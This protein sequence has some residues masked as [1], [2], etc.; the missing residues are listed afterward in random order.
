MMSK[1]APRRSTSWSSRARAAARSLQRLHHVAE[2]ADL[3]AEGAGRRVTHIGGEEPDGVVAP[4]VPEPALEQVAVVHEVMDRHE[5]DRGDAETA[6]VVDDRGMSDAGVGAAEMLGHVGM[7][8]SQALD[9]RLVDHGLVPRDARRPIVT[10]RERGVDDD[11]LRHAVRAVALVAREI[12]VGV[13]DRVPEQR[14]AP[15]HGARERAR[16]RVDQK[17]R[18]VEAVPRRGVIRPMHPVPVALAG[19]RVGKVHVPDMVAPLAHRDPRDLLTA[20]GPVEEAELDALGV[21]RE[22][23]KVDAATIP[24]RAG[25]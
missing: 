18:R 2:L 15:L 6:Q 16:V 17:L 10:P 8:G 22:E 24:G 9:V 1:N 3:L 20:V 14:V 12:G 23:G 19:A 5:L 13:S 4:V 25:G 11:G 7:P 21:L